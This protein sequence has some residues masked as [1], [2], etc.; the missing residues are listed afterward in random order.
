MLPTLLLAH[1]KSPPNMVPPS[2]RFMTSRTQRR[3]RTAAIT[4]IASRVMI[5]FA[6]MDMLFSS[7]FPESRTS[8]NVVIIGSFSNE[9]ALHAANCFDCSIKGFRRLPEQHRLGAHIQQGFGQGLLVLRIDPGQSARQNG[10]HRGDRF[11]I[12]Q[13]RFRGCIRRVQTAV[14]VLGADGLKNK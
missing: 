9:I 4:M 1:R 14:V 2:I 12:F 13:Q 5:R 11:R 8:E 10:F 6:V 7:C 3:P